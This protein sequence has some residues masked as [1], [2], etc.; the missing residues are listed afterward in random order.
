M[1]AHLRGIR[2]SSKK[3]NIVA[4]LIRKKDVLEALNILKFTA[5][6]SAK[7][8]YKVLYSAISNAEKN[9]D[10]NRANLKIKEIVITKG[11]F[12]K[13]FLPS[14]RGRALRLNKPT[15]HISIEL[16]DK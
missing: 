6:K 10:K 7:V 12:L 3:A 4:G 16:E 9:N 11:T 15:A 5:K 2:I 13:R 1:K 14:T 8:L